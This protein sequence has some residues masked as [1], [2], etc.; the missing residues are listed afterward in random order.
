MIIIKIFHGP[1]WAFECAAY[2][3]GSCTCETKIGA[4]C[5][6]KDGTGKLLVLVSQSSSP[7]GCDLEHITAS[8]SYLACKMD[9]ETHALPEV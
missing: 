3:I 9:A 5:Y 8:L 4:R 1:L 2:G 6:K 7:L